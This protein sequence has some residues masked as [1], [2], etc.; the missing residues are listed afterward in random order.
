MSAATSS[1]GRR[2]WMTR[3]WPRPGGSLELRTRS[4]VAGSAELFGCCAARADIPQRRTDSGE[5]ALFVNSAMVRD[6]GRASTSTWAAS[7]RTPARSRPLRRRSRRRTGADRTGR[8]PYDVLGI[9]HSGNGPCECQPVSGSPPRPSLANTKG[10]AAVVVAG[11]RVNSDDEFLILASYQGAARVVAGR[12]RRPP[13]GLSS[14]ASPRR[15]RRPSAETM[16]SAARRRS[17][18]CDRRNCMLRC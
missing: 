10:R 7:F 12:R 11:V 13:F 16:A 3:S 18:G 2:C 1:C 17:T 5:V 9:S 15:L 8:P 14:R 6:A 4:A